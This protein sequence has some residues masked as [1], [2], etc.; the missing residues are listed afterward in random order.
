MPDDPANADELARLAQQGQQ[1][2]HAASEDRSQVAQLEANQHL[3]VAIGAVRGSSLRRM[4]LV[5][6][7]AGLAV[8]IV[9]VV[10]TVHGAATAATAG[11]AAAANATTF[12][13]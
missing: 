5:P 12:V 9:G 3:R 11:A 1:R 4:L 6:M 8:A 10:L 13:R 7:L 2:I